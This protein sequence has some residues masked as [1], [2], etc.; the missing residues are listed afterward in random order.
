[1]SVRRRIDEPALPLP[2]RTRRSNIGVTSMT[3]STR[4]RWIAAAAAAVVF[5]TLALAADTAPNLKGKWVGKSHSIVAGSG[6]HWPTSAGTFEKPGLFE[7]DLVIEI[8]GQDGRRFWGVTTL[9]GKG[10]TTTE[11]FIG[12][13][14]GKGNREFVIADTDGIFT[15]DV[16]R[17]NTLAF[18][19]AHAGGK[20]ASAVVSCSEAKRTP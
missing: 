11:G 9:S 13:L 12:V 10:E 1:M 18:C 15:G 14:S 4:L 2:D 7:K 6:G 16:R 5:P 17:K 20:N 19:Y 8:T 3:D